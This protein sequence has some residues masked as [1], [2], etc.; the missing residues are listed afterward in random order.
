MNSSKNKNNSCPSS[1]QKGKELS[2][3]FKKGI[4][5]DDKF[6]LILPQNEREFS[7]END[8]N[9]KQETI[10]QEETINSNEELNQNNFPFSF[11]S[12]FDFIPEEEYEDESINNFDA[13]NYNINFKDKK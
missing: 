7:N 1:E 13:E 6:F 2:K 9:L 11:Q 12:F 10:T 5:A 3:K 4:E 8:S